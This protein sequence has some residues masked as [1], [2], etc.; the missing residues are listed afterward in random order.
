MAFLSG[1]VGGYAD[2][3]AEQ[4]RTNEQRYQEMLETYRARALE[5][6]QTFNKTKQ[7][8][9]AQLRGLKNFATQHF[10]GDLDAAR[11]YVD[12]FG[13]DITEAH[14]A[15]LDR[16]AP[17]WS[18][19]TDQQMA[20]AGL[21]GTAAPT[22]Q[23]SGQAAATGDPMRAQP[24]GTST[25]GR[26]LYDDGQG[27]VYSEKTVTFPIGDKWYT[28]PSVDAQGNTLTEDQVADYVRQHGPVDPIT[29]ERFPVF[30]TQQEAEAYAQQRS[31]TRLPSSQEQ[32]ASDGE[33]GLLDTL[34]SFIQERASRIF[35]PPGM[36]E[37]RQQVAEEMG[38][39]VEQLNALM[40]YN[41]SL[42]PGY[43]PVAMEHPR[44]GIS[45]L[46]NV[47]NTIIRDAYVRGGPE[48]AVAAA[49]G[50]EARK[51]QRAQSVADAL[52]FETAR[53]LGIDLASGMPPIGT[54][55]STQPGPAGQLDRPNQSS[56]GTVPMIE[57]G[58]TVVY[59][60]R[61]E[62]EYNAVPSGANYVHP[63]DGVERIKP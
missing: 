57:R 30:S 25:S 12:L 14:K 56:S 35:N 50:L 40:S 60:P 44:L 11:S 17:S 8:Q 1:L 4:M 28:F 41:Y 54:A 19:S 2:A 36:P 37:V 21:S 5:A 29:G 26:P 24:V 42:D 34:T 27:N 43:T 48:A 55:D 16:G 63:Q 13:G 49:Q 51:G 18:G 52:R 47:E 6:Y 38:M 9:Q 7:A 23:A 58:S 59:Q 10:G 61:T 22:A 3:K 15:I 53:L 31:S 32:P 62:A 33:A 46:S 39:D 45:D 20:N